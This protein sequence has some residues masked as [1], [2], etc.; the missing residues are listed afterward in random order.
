[1]CTGYYLPKVEVK[2]YSV[3]IDDRNIFH[4]PIKDHIKT[5]ENRKIATSQGD[6][7]TTGCLLGYS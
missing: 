3:K 1:M 7:Y 5:Y 4:Q 6:D 2:D